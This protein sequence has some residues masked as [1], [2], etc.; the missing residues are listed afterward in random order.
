MGDP[1]SEH[2]YSDNV[3]NLGETVSTVRAWLDSTIANDPTLGS[4]DNLSAAFNNAKTD[5]SQLD[6]LFHELESAARH[7]GNRPGINTEAGSSY[8]KAGEIFEEAKSATPPEFRCQLGVESTRLLMQAYNDEIDQIEAH[9]QIAEANQS[10]MA[11]NIDHMNLPVTSFAQKESE[12]VLRP[13]EFVLNYNGEDSKSE[14]FDMDGFIQLLY[15]KKELGNTLA[16]ASNY[17][18]NASGEDIRQF[19]DKIKHFDLQDIATQVAT[20]MFGVDT[21][22]TQIDIG[23]YLKEILKQAGTATPPIPNAAELLK[24]ALKYIRPES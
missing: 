14:G 19:V 8:Q 5:P 11:A 3:A 18:H 20:D 16:S 22:P 12:T 17:H 10:H 15:S 13:L 24:E 9:M 2:E 23:S 21:N 1:V 6:S 7:I 4:L